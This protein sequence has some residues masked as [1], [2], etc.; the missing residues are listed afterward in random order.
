MVAPK[1]IKVRIK[2]VG[3]GGKKRLAILCFIAKLL[4]IKLEAKNDELK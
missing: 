3:F 2:I 4:N 1:Y